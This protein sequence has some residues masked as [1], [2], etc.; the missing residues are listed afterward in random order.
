MQPVVRGGVH[1][2][3]DG[4]GGV[5]PDQVQQRE[6]PHRQTAAQL[7]GRV[8]VLA[9]GV[10]RLVHGCGLV[11]VA[12]Q[13]AVGDEP[14]PVADRDRLLAQ[15]PGE[16]GDRLDGRRRGQHGGD[17]L[18]QFHGRRRVEEVQAEHALGVLRLGG[19]PGHRQ[20]VGARGQDRGGRDDGV[21]LPE[22]LL[23]D[24]VRLRHDL[25]DELGVRGGLEIGEGAEPGEDV[26]P[27]LLGDP[28]APHG[29]GGGGLQRG[30]GLAGGRVTDV[31]T[32]DLAPGT[33]QDLGDTGAHGAEADDGD[34]AEMGV[35]HGTPGMSDD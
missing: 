17:H 9:G 26:A 14:R 30:D 11:E 15:L 4:A 12:E 5:D 34:A 31:D 33:G 27:L 7:H 21:E 3:Q 16:R 8:D 19:E 28:L 32:D 23:L 20:G 18:D 6:R 35:H 1:R 29:A 25:D 24:L 13:Q 2:L 10:V 22:D